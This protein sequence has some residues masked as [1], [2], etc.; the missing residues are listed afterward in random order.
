MENPKPVKTEF[1]FSEGKF[2][3]YIC[4]FIFM[5]AIGLYMGTAGSGLKERDNGWLIVCLCVGILWLYFQLIKG[6]NFNKPVL[7]ISEDGIMDHRKM[8][9]LIPWSII[10]NVR[11]R[12][13]S[14]KWS[15][16]FQ[17]LELE[18][19]DVERVRS[20]FKASRFFINWGPKSN[21]VPINGLDGTLEELEAAIEAM[22]PKTN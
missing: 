16:K 20:M 21:R 7:I 14:L 11:C 19:N 2:T 10:N 12:E 9:G 18:L 22:R 8:T 1:C 13:K 17:F 3:F 6:F 4:F 5:G 15:V